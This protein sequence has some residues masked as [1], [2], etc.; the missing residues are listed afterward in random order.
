MTQENET[1]ATQSIFES[2]FWKVA[3]I[4]LAV[5]LI[6]VGPTYV[7]YVLYE[8]HMDYI[9]TVVVGAVLFIVGMVFLVFLVRKK[10]IS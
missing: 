6:F 7:P 9:A 1:P 5:L 3:F 10:V 4:I 2:K 8:L